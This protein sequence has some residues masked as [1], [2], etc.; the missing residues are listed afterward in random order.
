[1]LTAFASR[2]LLDWWLQ[3]TS[4][5]VAKQLC[6]TSSIVKL[7]QH[8]GFVDPPRDLIR[9]FRRA[10]ANK[11]WLI[12]HDRAPKVRKQGA[13]SAPCNAEPHGRMLDTVCRVLHV[14]LQ[15]L[16]RRPVGRSQTLSTGSQVD[17]LDPEVRRNPAAG[18]HYSLQILRVNVRCSFGF[19]CSKRFSQPRA[20]VA[21]S[22]V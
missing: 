1:M 3:W 10:V 14:G 2:E 18:V 8:A 22:P 13:M 7:S 5:C 11:P 19:T 16:A 15:K 4:I 21:T 17:G 6:R 20:D 12:C 9:G